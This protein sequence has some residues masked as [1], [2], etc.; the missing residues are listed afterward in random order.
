MVLKLDE[1]LLRAL[2]HPEW[3][4]PLALGT[5]VHEAIAKKEMMPIAEY[6]AARESIYQRYWP[7]APWGVLSWGL[8]QLGL[9][10]GTPGE[11]H[12]PV[13]TLVIMSNI[14]DASKALAQ[15]VARYTSR[16]DRIWSKKIFC[17]EFANLFGDKNPLSP[18]DMNVLLTFISRE[19]NMAA[20]DG[21]TIKFAGSSE[22]KPP[23]ITPED[24]TIASLKTLIIDLETQ[25]DVLTARVDTLTMTAR[26][27]VLRKNRVSA[28]A[29][30]RSKKLA[31]SNLSQQSA[32]L[33]Q[34]EEVYSKIGQA[35][36]QVELV[37]IMEGST[38]VLRVLNADMGG[39]E[40]VDEVVNQLNQQ[41]SQVDEIGNI[42]AEAGQGSTVI[43][44]T[45][46][47]DELERLEGEDRE[48]EQELALNAKEEEDSRA[49]EVMRLRLEELKAGEQHAAEVRHEVGKASATSDILN[50]SVEDSTMRLA[51]I[52]ID[53]EKTAE[54]AI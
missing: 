20:Y 22:L 38:G 45:E 41:M 34:L 2:E 54:P 19:K 33:A 11:D 51:R 30:L 47:D 28:L 42:M 24:T 12:L 48:R 27:A 37:R 15:R 50:R 3:G 7:V 26:D 6:Q 29:A 46:L 52:S 43:D 16:T 44:E 21:Q 25:M 39:V 8:R 49:A 23:T 53:E 32:T 36:D 10:G 1:E 9:A 13:G 35:S 31:E 5:V 14:E 40:R 4:R 17:R 18:T